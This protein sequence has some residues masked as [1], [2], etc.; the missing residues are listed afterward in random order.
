MGNPLTE[1]VRLGQSVWHDNIRREL[2]TSGKLKK[3]VQAGEITGL[4]SNPTIF[5]QAIAG[6][7]DY[8]EQV[9]QLAREG[10]NAEEIFDAL[11]IDDIRNAADVFRLV[12]DRTGGNDGYVSI[13]VAPKWANDTDTTIEEAH[14]L[15]E[16]VHRPNLMVKIPGTKA[17]IPAIRQCIADGLNINVTLIFSLERYEEVMDA[18]LQG[19]I[20]RVDAGKTV[21]Q[22]ASVA[23]FFVS[24]VDT[25]VDKLLDE[26]SKTASDADKMKLEALKGKAAVANAKLAYEQFRKKF[27]TEA[28]QALLNQGARKQR[29][30]WASTSTKN[31]AYPDTYYVEAL[32]GPDTV[33][34]MPPATIDAYRDHGEPQIRLDKD[35]DVARLA[36]EELAAV[37]IRMD[38]VTHKLEIDGV[39][40]FAKSFDSLIATVEQQRRTLLE[41]KKVA[42]VVRASSPAKKTKKRPAARKKPARKKP[43]RVAKARKAKPARATRKKIVK[44]ASRARGRVSSK[45]KKK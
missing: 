32:I 6:S 30:L 27:S 10:K 33:D 25:L 21:K 9:S 19:L 43:T 41:G 11:A 38:E 31:P 29:P 2:L 17:G 15:W 22:T 39:A 18:Y 12:Y 40:S 20:E 8:D 3:M 44:K 5:E 42:G 7:K 4:T 24:R 45:R 37:G 35:L 14:R 23:S 36:M 1:L 34:T 16:T 13:E 26:K 28:A